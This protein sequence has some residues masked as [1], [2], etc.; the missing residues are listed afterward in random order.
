[1]KPISISQPNPA[2]Q[3]VLLSLFFVLLSSLLFALLWVS[4]IVAA[5]KVL[6]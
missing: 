1:M 3:K 5:I 6:K 2:K 4:F